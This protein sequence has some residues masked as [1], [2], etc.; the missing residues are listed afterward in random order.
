MR[1]W[2]TRSCDASSAADAYT[3]RAMNR[4]PQCG[5]EN[6]ERA[7]F[8]LACGRQLPAAG[9]PQEVRKTVTVLFSDLTGSTALGERMDPEALRAKGDRPDEARLGEL[10]ARE[11]A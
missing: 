3:A 6:P 4:C 2:S 9:V 11:P 10:L 5:E 7:R 8:C 1:A